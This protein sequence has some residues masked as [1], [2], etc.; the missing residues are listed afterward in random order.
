MIIVVQSYINSH[1]FFMYSTLSS[2]G[3][4]RNLQ[5]VNMVV[6]VLKNTKIRYKITDDLIIL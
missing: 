6:A 5:M 3:E 4:Y 1:S 2:I